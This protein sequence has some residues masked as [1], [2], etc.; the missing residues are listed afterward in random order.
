SGAIDSLRFTP[1]GKTLVSACRNGV[2]L[3][4]VPGGKVRARLYGPGGFARVAVSADGRRLAAAFGGSL[5]LYD[6]A[7]GKELRT[8]GGRGIFPALRGGGG[9]TIWAAGEND[10]VFSWGDATAAKQRLSF[11]A[12]KG[13]PIRYLASSPEG[14]LL[15]SGVPFEV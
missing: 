5:K 2:I 15:A 7:T 9:G 6:I 10:G 1:D 4:E 12:Y 14:E 13:G 11:R 3:R 8:V